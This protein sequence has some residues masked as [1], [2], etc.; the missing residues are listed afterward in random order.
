ML[1]TAQLERLIEVEHKGASVLE[2]K[3][4]VKQ[5][6]FGGKVLVGLP[7]VMGSAS[8]AAKTL[9][10]QDERFICYDFVRSDHGVWSRPE[11]AASLPLGCLSWPHWLHRLHKLEVLTPPGK[12]W[13]WK[14]RVLHNTVII[15]MT[16]GKDTGDMGVTT[17]VNR[18]AGL[19]AGCVGSPTICSM[20]LQPQESPRGEVVIETTA[21]HARELRKTPRVTQIGGWRKAAG[22]LVATTVDMPEADIAGHTGGKVWAKTSM[23]AQN[24]VMIYATE[25]QW[26]SIAPLLVKNDMGGGVIRESP[27]CAIIEAKTA[28]DISKITDALRKWRKTGE[29]EEDVSFRT[30][31]KRGEKTFITT[32][33][34]GEENLTTLYVYD[35]DPR[36]TISCCEAFLG[37]L[38]VDEAEIHIIEDHTP[39]KDD[40]SKYIC[41]RTVTMTVPR[42]AS[43]KIASVTRELE[44]EGDMIIVRPVRKGEGAAE[45]KQQSSRDSTDRKAVRARQ[46][47]EEEE[48][49]E[50]AA[51]ARKEEEEAATEEDMQ[52]EQ[53]DEAPA[54]AEERASWKA[55]TIVRAPAI[56]E[57]DGGTDRTEPT[58]ETL[59]L[60]EPI[61]GGNGGWIVERLEAEPVKCRTHNNGSTDGWLVKHD[62]AVE[63]GCHTSASKWF[64]GRD[65]ATEK[66]AHDTKQ[67]WQEKINRGV[68][69]HE[70]GL[71]TSTTQTRSRYSLEQARTC[72]CD[73]AAALTTLA[74]GSTSIAKEA[75]REVSRRNTQSQ[76]SKK[77][78]KDKEGDEK[79]GRGGGAANQQHE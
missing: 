30:W 40:A 52:V 4:D 68:L 7:V 9:V 20:R 64:S 59:K 16:M 56:Q 54:S 32:G 41:T 51:G 50:A 76:I 10:H 63:K 42:N 11:N 24:G 33:K 12:P 21:E 36:F 62:D 17:E 66:E 49:E 29:L 44:W 48:E 75:R 60:I 3:A 31:T 43:K 65:A 58:I 5:V 2:K 74:N 69:V 13:S 45:G 55:D 8:D 39:D 26:A 61:D 79:N 22:G 1:D 73:E 18:Q 71:D 53:A 67:S 34:T 78:R 14:G 46:D 15:R 19:L 38:G 72:D 37:A 6:S 47:E 27:R 23:R 57:A 77:A 70:K 25:E 28:G 35:A